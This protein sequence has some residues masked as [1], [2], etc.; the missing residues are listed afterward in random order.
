MKRYGRLRPPA[1]HPPAPHSTKNAMV[2]CF[3]K[4]SSAPAHLLTT[5]IKTAKHLRAALCSSPWQMDKPAH[6]CSA[7]TFRCARGADGRNR[8][9]A[10][11]PPAPSSFHLQWPSAAARLNIHAVCMRGWPGC[12]CRPSV[13]PTLAGRLVPSTSKFKKALAPVCHRQVR[14]FFL[15]LFG[16]QNGWLCARASTPARA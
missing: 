15:N 4:H 1:P 14:A 7:L 3:S 6:E 8:G 10:T 12:S 9:N 5:V 11:E 13:W 2:L 16:T